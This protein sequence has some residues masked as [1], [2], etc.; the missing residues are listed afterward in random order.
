M[1]ATSD[2]GG[3]DFCEEGVKIDPTSGEV[4]GRDEHGDGG[5]G[6]PDAFKFHLDGVEILACERAVH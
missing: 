6:R 5:E 2:H 3:I 4:S 1:V